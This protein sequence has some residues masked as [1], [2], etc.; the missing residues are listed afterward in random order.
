MYILQEVNF[1]E[2]PDFRNFASELG[3]VLSCTSSNIQHH[4]SE[5]F[6]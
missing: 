4:N 6:P 2:N 1:K 3:R 5:L